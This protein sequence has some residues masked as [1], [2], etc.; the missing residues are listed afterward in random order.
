M[1]VSDNNPLYQY[2]Y[3]KVPIITGSNLPTNYDVYYE[4]IAAAMKTV[5][6]GDTGS[7]GDKGDKGDKGNTGATGATG[8]TGPQGPTGPAGAD[9]VGVPSGGTTGQV[10]SKASG[11][12]YDT[13][14]TTPEAGGVQ[15]VQVNG[16][17]VVTDGVANVPIAKS[18]VLGVVKTNVTYG[19]TINSSGELYI[20]NEGEAGIKR[21]NG[22]YGPIVSAVQHMSAFYGLAKAAGSDEKNS[23]L[24]FGTYTDVAKSAIQTMLGISGIIAPVE[25]ATASKP[26]GIGDAFLHGG[27]LY[28]ATAAIAANDAIAPGTNCEQTTIVDLLKGA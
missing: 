25:G 3:G 24:P 14:W 26:Y 15:D 6:K 12:D 11:T 7:K 20:K 18:N 10:L 5:K 2:D 17:S 16:T 21:G 22:T 13:E 4:N 27:A 28:K 19:I 1:P 8:A 23:T 9:G